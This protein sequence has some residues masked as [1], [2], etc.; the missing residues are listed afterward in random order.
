MILLDKLRTWLRPAPTPTPAPAPAPEAQPDGRDVGLHDAVLGGW[1]RGETGELLEGFAIAASDTVLD[2]GCG[3]GGAIGFCAHLGAQVIYSDIDA[4]KVA[5][6][7]HK[8]AAAGIAAS[9]HRGFASDSDPLPLPDQ[10]ASRILCMEVLE[11]VDDPARILRELWRVGQPGAHYLLTVPDPSSEA[12]LKQVAPPIFFEKPNH[13]RVFSHD[14]FERLVQEAGFI[15]ERRVTSGFY[16]SLWWILFC[17][18]DQQRFEP[19][20]HP[21]LEQ[22][23]RTWALLLQQPQGP[24]LKQAL[25]AAL[26]KSQAIIARKPS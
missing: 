15:I 3:D 24:R 9:Q 10:L 19:P 14:D 13:I 5:A 7:R 12:V 26:P 16:W 22:W 6:V 17:A 11:H 2:V 25:D 21:L 23:S 1:F 18:C 8:L 20:W 4:A